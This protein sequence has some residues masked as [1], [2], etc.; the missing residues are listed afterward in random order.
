MKKIKINNLE[1]IIK[2]NNLFV[3]KKRLVNISLGIWKVE[4]YLEPICTNLISECEA[5]SRLN[6]ECSWKTQKDK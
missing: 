5:C 6:D 4:N 2:D 1:L 3:A